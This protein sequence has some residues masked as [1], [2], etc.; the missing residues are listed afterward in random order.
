MREPC[1]SAWR[2]SSRAAWPM[3]CGS[4]R[5]RARRCRAGCAQPQRAL[6]VV[7]VVVIA[8]FVARSTPTLG[9]AA[10]IV[11]GA[12]I[13]LV[14]FAAS[15]SVVTDNLGVFDT[16]FQPAPVTAFTRSFFGEPLQPHRHAAD[17]R[18]GSQR[19]CRACWP[20]RRRWS[21]RR[22]SSRPGRRRCRSVA[23]T[24]R[25]PP[26]RSTRSAATWRGGEFHLVLTAP[27]SSDPRVRW[28]KAH[29]LPVHP[30]GPQPA[31]ALDVSFCLPASAK[32][33]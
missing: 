14:P 10:A 11:A 4:S 6:A 29:C 26:P 8:A 25:R 24:A 17:D 7:A 19:R 30:T 33:G 27:E 9:A 2:R 18:A 16:P 12:A 21:R 28:I 32:A 23:T 15:A 13:V 1:S 31:L 3:Q 5:R 22:S 20:R